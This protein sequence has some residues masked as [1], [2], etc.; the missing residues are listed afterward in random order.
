MSTLHFALLLMVTLVWG[1]HFSVIKATIDDIPTLF[2]V[3]V[4]MAF[5]AL[6]L[7]PFLRWHKG[8]MLLIL[9]AGAGIGGINYALMFTGVKY[10]TASIGALM[11]ETYMPIATIFSVIFL[12]E[13]IGWRRILGLVLAFAGVVIIVSAGEEATGADRLLLGATLI[14]CAATAE[15][16]AA[17]L[18]KRV[19]DVSALQLLAWFGIVGALVT[20]T[21][22]AIWEEGQWAAITGENRVTIW[23]ALGYSVVFASIVGHATYYWLLQRIPISQ[24]AGAT[25]MTTVFAVLFGVTLLDDPLTLQFIFGGLVTLSGVAIIVLRS[26]RERRADHVTPN[27]SHP[28]IEEETHGT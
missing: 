25:V 21:A 16:G 27:T 15:A 10:T 13:R 1:L 6:L 22:S 8:R 2:Y 28:L 14:I 23:A 19:K 20:G 17:I 4:R 26:S 24:V 7:S 9:L 12:G 18:I 3:A 11:I 5:V